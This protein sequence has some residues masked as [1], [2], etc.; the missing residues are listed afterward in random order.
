MHAH[1]GDRVRPAGE[2]LIL[3][4]RLSKGW[5]SGTPKCP[6]TAVQWDER[7][8]EVLSAEL[9]PAGGVRYVLGAWS[10]SATIRTFYIYDAA[11]EVRLRADY[12]LAQRQRKHSILAR[13][14]GFALGHLPSHVQNHFA[15]ELGV[16]PVRMTL[17]SLIPPMIFFGTC[18]WLIAG[19][20]IA[21]ERSPVPFW[22]FAFAVAMFVDSGIRFMVTMSQARGIGSF[23]GTILYMLYRLVASGPAARKESSTFMIPPPDDVALQDELEVKSAFLTLLSANEQRLLGE[24]YGFDHRRYAANVAWVI[25]LC[26]ALG[27]ASMWVEI[28]E[29]AGLSARLSLLCAALVAL[30]QGIRLLRFSRGPAGSVF[31]VL[32]RP[33]ARALLAR[34]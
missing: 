6:G 14:A 29:G 21:Q 15:N 24:R 8:Y 18:I 3:H 25:L 34:N 1:G 32:V 5:V 10:D 16:F 2:T 19:A 9:L 23:P 28:R 13:L 20:R 30:E 27:A 4:A 33:F 22:V 26:A 7:C 12:E 17:L 11:S 31:A